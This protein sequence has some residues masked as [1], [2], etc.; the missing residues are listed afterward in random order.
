[1][2]IYVY[3]VLQADGTPG[4]RFEWH[5][6]MSEPALT[7]HPETGEAVRRVLLPPHLGTRYS[8][9]QTRSRLDNKRVEKAGFT[10]YER[11]KMTGRYHRVAGRDGPETI[12]RPPPG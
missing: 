2:P 3:E 11:D 7:Q 8:E 10:K 12:N 6:A 1:M 9:G 5:Q 4:P